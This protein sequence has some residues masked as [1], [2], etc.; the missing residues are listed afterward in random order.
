MLNHS[1][2]KEFNLHVNENLLSH[3]R[4]STRT[5]FKNEANGNSEKAY[6][7]NSQK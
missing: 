7:P 5:R 4:M 1:Y 2:E 6:R 3:E